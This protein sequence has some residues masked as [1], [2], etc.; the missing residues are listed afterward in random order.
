[1]FQDAATPANPRQTLQ[2]TFQ[3]RQVTRAYTAIKMSQTTNCCILQ[4]TLMCHASLLPGSGDL[5]W[6]GNKLVHIAWSDVRQDAKFG[7]NERSVLL[8]KY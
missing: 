5:V 2:S 1:M 6:Q 7:Q 8:D 4:S 3:D